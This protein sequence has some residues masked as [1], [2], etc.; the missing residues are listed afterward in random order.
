MPR[1]ILEIYF[2]KEIHCL[3]CPV[4]ND[5][6]DDCKMQDCTNFESWDD[7]MLHCPLKPVNEGDNDAPSNT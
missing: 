7:Q 3:D 2:E 5:D 6:T 1:A 4:R